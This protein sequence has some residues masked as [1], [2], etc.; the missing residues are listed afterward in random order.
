MDSIFR[1][2]EAYKF[3][4]QQVKE[5][6]E[7]QR[8]FGSDFEYSLDKTDGFSIGGADSYAD[9]SLKVQ[10]SGTSG[11]IYIS[12]EKNIGVWEFNGANLL[13]SGQQPTVLLLKNGNI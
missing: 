13:I 9:F 11:I 10:G 7:V 12:M 3:A 2:S 4:V 8:V 1:T 5:N 6:P